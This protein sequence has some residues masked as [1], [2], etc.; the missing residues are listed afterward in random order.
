MFQ[1]VYELGE[2]RCLCMNVRL[3]R[4]IEN[5]FSFINQNSKTIIQR[6]YITLSTNCDL[7]AVFPLVDSQASDKVYSKSRQNGIRNLK[8]SH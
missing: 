2:F 5:V 7:L 4:A 3:T 8:K 1:N 6:S